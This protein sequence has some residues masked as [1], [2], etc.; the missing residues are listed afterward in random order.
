MTSSS[1]RTPSRSRRHSAKAQSRRPSS[2][3]RVAVWVLH[4]GLPL[5]GV[6]VLVA[7]PRLDVRLEHHQAHFW[8]VSVAAA[9][10]ALLAARLSEVARRR[11]DARLFLVSLAFFS[12]AG[13]LFLHALA[14]PAV[15]LG[16]KNAGF[17]VAT[18]VGLVLAAVFAAASAVELT[19]RRAAIVLRWHGPLRAAL[20]AMMIAWAVVSLA[21]LP[22]LDAAIDPKEAHGPL[23]V[24]AGAGTTLFLLAG[25]SYFQI[26]RRRPAAMLLGVITAFALL[27]EALITLAYA[28]NWQASWW[29]WHLLMAAG[30]GFI[31]YSAYVQ[32]RREGSATA[33]FNSITLEATLQ[34][35]RA[36][37]GSAL[38]AMVDA[39]LHRAEAGS[40]EPSAPS[41]AAPLAERFDLTEGQVEVLEQ[42]AGAL[43]AEREQALRLAALVAVGNEARVIV[44]ESDFLGRAMSTVA[45]AFGRDVIRVGLVEEGQVRFPASLSSMSGSEPDE[46]A[47]AAAE[48]VVASRSAAEESDAGVAR[49]ILPLTVKDRVAGVLEVRRTGPGFAAR[50][51]AVLESFASQMSIALEN[52][53]LYRQIDV[54]FRQY[55]SPEIVTA[56]LADPSQAGLGGAL[57]E[58]TS[59]FAD[60]R[61]FT[62]FS[63]RTAPGEVVDLLNRYFGIAIP[64]LLDHGGTVTQ[65]AGDNVMAIFN[66]PTRQPDHALLAARAALAVQRSTAS[67]APDDPDWPRF[68][69]GINTGPALVGNVGAQVRC[70][71]ANG[72]SVNLAARLEAV[73]EPGGV[74]I[75]AAT[76]AALGEVATVESMGF[77]TVKGKD[78]PVE[79]FA[80][81]DLHE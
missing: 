63:E 54:L 65:F 51:R 33:I 47:A 62:S 53:R 72:D 31:A 5:L 41:V 70:Y 75:G 58:V 36:E 57:V 60:L 67:E 48:R 3:A 20:L 16:A 71:T 9:V 80:L 69:I 23:V 2:K 4:L 34:R 38:D 74:V 55:M 12:G 42:A 44:E 78:Q 81:L 24:V 46:G 40:T 7:Q 66:A 28:R 13:F 15:I 27:A 8:L 50:D 19:P 76:R 26:H 59:L 61:G 29:T 77:L 32:Y 56:L 17:D 10:S 79:A 18:P 39:M 68:R 49:L 73:A 6:W 64:L 25:F 35:I 21:G 30:F 11:S 37:Y 43:A 45:G 14:T 1:T 52:A 22:P